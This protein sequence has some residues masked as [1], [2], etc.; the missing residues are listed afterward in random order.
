[1][2]EYAVVRLVG[3]IAARRIVRTRFVAYGECVTDARCARGYGE[4]YECGEYGRHVR[5]SRF[6]T[7][8]YGARQVARAIPVRFDHLHRW[9]RIAARNR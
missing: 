9:E 4:E 7:G 2:R 6:E 3:R 8:E 5:P 1:M